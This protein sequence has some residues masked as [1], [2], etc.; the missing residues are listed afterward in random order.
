MGIISFIPSFFYS[1]LCYTPPYPIADLSDQV[2]IVTGSNTGLGYEAAKHFVRLGANKVILA[3]R[4]ESKGEDAKKRI[5]ES[6]NVDPSRIEVWRLDMSSTTSVK[7]FALQVKQLNRLDAIVENAGVMTN[8][9]KTVDGTECTILVNVINTVLLA[10]LTLPKLQE[11]GRKFKTENK[12]ILVGSDLHLLA[13]LPERNVPG[14]TVYEALNCQET[15]R[16]SERYVGTSGSGGNTDSTLLNLYKIRYMNTK[17][18]L[19]LACRSL[20]EKNP[21]SS[22]SPVVINYCNPG[23]C[24]SEID[25]DDRGRLAAFAVSTTTSIFARSTEVGS[26]T[27]VNA[28]VLSGKESHGK[29]VTN[30]TPTR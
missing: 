4:T 8:D 5:V 26:R 28:V 30:C 11:S 10:L 17:L 24:I 2:L 13:T 27:Y 23:M 12:L 18:L 29:F 25:R 21:V 16:M 7:A 15:S 6:L 1:Q 22:S 20:A 3:V 19:M 9:W 14:K